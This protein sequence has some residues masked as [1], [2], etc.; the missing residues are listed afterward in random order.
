V[1]S[2]LNETRH[3]LSLFPSKTVPEDPRRNK[4]WDNDKT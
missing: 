2:T 3:L 1:L 4:C